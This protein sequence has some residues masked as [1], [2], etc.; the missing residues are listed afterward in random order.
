MKYRISQHYYSQLYGSQLW[1]VDISYYVVVKI[2]FSN[3]H[4]LFGQPLQQPFLQS[5][6]PSLHH[7]LARA[8]I[9]IYSYSYCYIAIAIAITYTFAIVYGV[10]EQGIQSGCKTQLYVARCGQLITNPSVYAQVQQYVAIASYIKMILL[11]AFVIAIR[12]AI[13]SF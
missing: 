9:V 13:A 1:D 6:Q 2:P 8:S 5:V 12:L 7:L 4:A 10:K 3:H 11:I